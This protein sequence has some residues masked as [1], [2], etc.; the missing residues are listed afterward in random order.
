MIGLTWGDPQLILTSVQWGAIIGNTACWLY[1]WRTQISARIVAALSTMMLFW[2]FWNAPIGRDAAL[3]FEQAG[4]LRACSWAEFIAACPKRAY[5]QNQTPFY[6]FYVSRFPVF[7]QHQLICLPYSL[8]AVLLLFKLYGRRAALLCATP[9]LAIIRTQPS[10]DFW[11]FVA[12]VL[13][14]RLA[15]LGR[16][17]LAALVYGLAYLIKPLVLVTLPAMLVVLRG[18]L[19]LSVLI[20]AGYIR[21][22]LQYPFGKFQTTFLLHQTLVQEAGTAIGRL[23]RIK[24]R[25]RLF[26]R[27][28]LPALP[29]YLFP[30]WVTRWATVGVLIAVGVLIGYGNVKY[31]VLALLC[32][33]RIDDDT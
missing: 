2:T 16:R 5:I 13:T 26:S 1:Q 24:N 29:V 12:M 6:P 22:S 20:W 17:D 3:L 4:Q 7:W 25:W 31:Q 14:F 8:A 32:S 11:L 9:L 28:A 15:Q 30:A 18:Y 23:T 10:T 19:L 27:P 21:V 33:A